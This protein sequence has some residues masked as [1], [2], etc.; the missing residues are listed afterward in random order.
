V[1][2]N[3]SKPAWTGLCSRYE[4]LFGLLKVDDAPDFVEVLQ[5]SILISLPSSAEINAIYVSLD[6]FVLKVERV[7]PN[8]NTNNGNVTYLCLNNLQSEIRFTH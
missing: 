5:V 3:H 8:V 7:L 4:A 6:I 2:T 1:L